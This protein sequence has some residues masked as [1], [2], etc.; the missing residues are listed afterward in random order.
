[1]VNHNPNVLFILSEN[2]NPLLKEQRKESWMSLLPAMKKNDFK[3][4][5]F[6]QHT[7][8]EIEGQ[9]VSYQILTGKNAGESDLPVIQRSQ[10][11]IGNLFQWSDYHTAYIGKWHFSEIKDENQQ[12]CFSP[13]EYGFNY[14]YGFVENKNKI[15]M[16]ENNQIIERFER[17]SNADVFKISEEMKKCTLEI[18]DTYSSSKKPFFIFHT[19][20]AEEL[21]ESKNAAGKAH[22]LAELINQLR[23]YGIYEETLIIIVSIQKEEKNGE[24]QLSLMIHC[25]EQVLRIEIGELPTSL[26]HIFQLFVNLLE[27]PVPEE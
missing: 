20:S 12:N 3:N 4:I 5:T 6:L 7:V 13:N 21:E 15:F 14:F 22:T 19:M 24:D 11:T 1:M 26:E 25:P 17:S 9:S 10:T 16:V 8:S 23:K 27:V 18:I 2:G